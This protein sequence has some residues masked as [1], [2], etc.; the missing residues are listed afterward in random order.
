MKRKGGAL[1]ESESDTGIWKSHFGKKNKGKRGITLPKNPRQTW[2]NLLLSGKSEGS[3]E[4]GVGDLHKKGKERLLKKKKEENFCKNLNLATE[5]PRCPVV[6][7]VAMGKTL[8]GR[9]R[10]GGTRRVE[11]WGRGGTCA[12]KGSRVEGPLLRQSG[13]AGRKGRTGWERGGGWELLYAGGVKSCFS[14]RGSP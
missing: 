14:S 8:L 12:R 1:R 3:E 4:A 6:V 10:L 2:G 5:V 9:P 11:G 7:G 13:R